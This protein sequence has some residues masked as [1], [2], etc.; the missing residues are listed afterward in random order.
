[1]NAKLGRLEE[2]LL[3]GY[4]ITPY[5]ARNHE[6]L[7]QQS[8]ENSDILLFLSEYVRECSVS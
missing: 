4:R 6:E 3:Q 8:I 5:A 2:K 1:M 7:Y